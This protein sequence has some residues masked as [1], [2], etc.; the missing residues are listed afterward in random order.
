MYTHKISYKEERF[1]P[2]RNNVSCPDN[3]R[4]INTLFYFPPINEVFFVRDVFPFDSTFA[5]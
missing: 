2:K 5:N 3:L 4:L 1:F